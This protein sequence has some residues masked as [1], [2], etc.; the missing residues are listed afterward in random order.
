M[1]SHNFIRNEVFDENIDRLNEL[2]RFVITQR[3]TA[4]YDALI[5]ELDAQRIELGGVMPRDQ[6]AIDVVAIRLR[7]VREEKRQFE[8][9]TKAELDSNLEKW[10]A[11]G[12][13]KEEDVVTS[14]FTLNIPEHS[15]EDW[16]AKLRADGVKPL[17]NVH[18]KEVKDC[19]YKNTNA[20][21]YTEDEH[22]AGLAAKD[23]YFSGIANEDNWEQDKANKAYERGSKIT[24][25]RS[26]NARRQPQNWHF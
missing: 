15:L 23:V 16:I 24:R 13:K 26:T 20:A 19:L 21:S 8:A 3:K 12:A 11:L 5:A 1:A 4:E 7:D 14:D 22:E 17:V 9:A 6:A 10:R 18:F 25:D 2:T